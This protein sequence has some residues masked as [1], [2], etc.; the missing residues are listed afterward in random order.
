MTKASPGQILLAIAAF[1]ATMIGGYYT[2]DAS[3]MESPSILAQMFRGD[4][5]LLTHGFISLF[6][7]GALAYALFKNRVVQVPFQQ[8]L[9]VSVFFVAAILFSIIFSNYRWPAMYTSLQWF[10]YIIAMGAAAALTGRQKGAWIIL[11]SVIAG[12]T[13][14][15][16]LGIWEYALNRPI[17]P[18]WR[19]FSLWSNPN[20]LAGML[21]LGF[22]LVL[23]FSLISQRTI[24]LMLGLCGFFIGVAIMFTQ[25][26]GA[27][28]AMGAGIVAFLILGYI[29]NP[30]T[31]SRVRSL[32]PTVLVVCSF[33][34]FM[35]LLR[36]VPVKV[37]NN[38]VAP[39]ALSRVS[40]AGAQADQSAG[41]RK[42]LWQSSVTLIKQSP[43]GYGGGSFVYIST[44]PG[45][46]TSTG[47]PHQ[48]FLQIGVEFGVLSLLA[49]VALGLLWFRDMFRGA[50]KLPKGQN[51]L[52][53]GVVAAIFAS[54][55]HCMIDSD[56]SYYGNGLVF[57]ILLGVG[58]QLC[59]DGVTPEAIPK[60]PRMI[61][62]SVSILCPLMLL[63]F[64]MQEA[65][66]ARIRT[67]MDMNEVQT[68]VAEVKDLQS[69][70]PADGETWYL[71]AL[72]S[73]PEQRI[74]FL[75]TA[76]KLTPSPRYFRLLARLQQ[77]VGNTSGALDSLSEALRLD[78]NNMLALK[79]L[80]EVYAILGSTESAK[81]TAERLIAVEQT[82][83]YQVRSIPEEIP[84]ETFAAR[85]YL[86]GQLTD[87]N[88]QLDILKPAV[89]GFRRYI[90][91]T[92]PRIMQNKTDL[93]RW[94]SAKA[95]LDSSAKAGAGM[96]ITL[97]QKSGSAADIADAKT[98]QTE[99]ETIITE[100][101]KG[102]ST[103][104]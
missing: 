9:F 65:K 91:I 50:S 41:F 81:Q 56:L 95:I 92:V 5:T 99:V 24:T 97:A 102:P 32:V 35:A 2:Q 79:Q 33:F 70:A 3:T 52:R 28:L 83:Y 38:V 68:A 40:A 53:A 73:P 25:S 54:V 101:K 26:K 71:S 82:P 19:I 39:V 31:K 59:A 61:G 94:E 1:L 88:K 15:S 55:A 11:G 13:L 46:T 27:I 66:Q 30:D 14:L 36:A 7:C 72:L 85:V 87:L 100:L 58:L 60:S 74:E 57:F 63:W 93:R 16:I 44:K 29:W 77:E 43:L 76:V 86:A 78:P 48:S 10:T 20:A 64:G 6:A 80:L 17:D 98:F 67:L 84:T 89:E 69:S 42:L 49:F 12:C 62:I 103:T 51:A 4:A 104:P 18:N 47:V 23:G 45:L 37:D 22:F 90:Q 75:K 34:G 8:T 96:Y 21:L